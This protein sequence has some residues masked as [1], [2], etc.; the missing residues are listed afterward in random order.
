[1]AGTTRDAVDT[2]FTAPDGTRYTLID[3]AGVRRRTAVAASPDG[4]E[5]RGSVGCFPFLGVHMLCI[6]LGD[7]RAME[8]GCRLRFGAI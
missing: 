5:V 8:D 2:E 4:A 6:A 1:M 3:T 7:A